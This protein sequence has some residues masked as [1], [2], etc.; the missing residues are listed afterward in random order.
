MSSN[1]EYH[2]SDDHIDYLKG[3]SENNCTDCMLQ[4]ADFYDKENN[5]V[6]RNFYYKKAEENGDPEGLFLYADKN[7]ITREEYFKIMKY[8]V[9]KYDSE[10][11]LYNLTLYCLEREEFNDAEIYIDRYLVKNNF[12]IGGGDSKNDDL[13][14]FGKKIQ[15]EKTEQF[16]IEIILKKKL[17][18]QYNNFYKKILKNNINSSNILYLY[19]CMIEFVI[20]INNIDVLEPVGNGDIILNEE[21]SIIFGN[22][23]DLFLYCKCRELHITRYKKNLVLCT[24]LDL[25]NIYS[26]YFSDSTKNLIYASISYNIDAYISLKILKGICKVCYRDSILFPDK[27]LNFCV[28]QSHF[29]LAN[30]YTSFDNCKDYIFQLKNRIDKLI[31]KCLKDKVKNNNIE[32]KKNFKPTD[33]NYLRLF[34]DRGAKI[35]KSLGIS[36]GYTENI[37]FIKICNND[38]TFGEYCTGH[39]KHLPSQ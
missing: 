26:K 15:K 18:S 11:A 13:E 38:T 5:I 28:C 17:G 24:I 14:L 22:I 23:V 3:C 12:T 25:C 8:L 21:E 20:I 32:I 33:N 36:Q 30:Y 4:L 1:C 7:Y 34:R 35:F 6:R 2:Y 29:K 39:Y 10:R 19:Y 27:N 31:M 16:L 9:D 37:D